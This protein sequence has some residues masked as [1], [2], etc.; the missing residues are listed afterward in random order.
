MPA[1]ATEVMS[2][3]EIA[4][5]RTSRRA[6]TRALPPMLASVF[7]MMT[8]VSMPAPIAPCAPE[9]QAAAG[10]DVVSAVGGEHQDALV[11][12]LAAVVPVLIRAPSAMYALVVSVRTF[13]EAEPA[14]PNRA[15]AE[16]PTASV[17]TSSNE[18]A[19]TARPLTTVACGVSPDFVPFGAATPAPWPLASTWAPV[20]M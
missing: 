8:P 14:T 11:A 17:K 12:A 10:P 15:A 6:S 13:T 20:P 7:L 2:S 4:R 3:S 5:T 1:T 18:V 16:A 19:V 9:G